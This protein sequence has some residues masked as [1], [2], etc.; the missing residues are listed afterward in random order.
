MLFWRSSSSRGGFFQFS[1]KGDAKCSSGGPP[2]LVAVSYANLLKFHAKFSDGGP[3]FDFYTKFIEKLMPNTL[4]AA[5]LLL[6]W[7]LLQFFIKTDVKRSSGCP[8]FV[9]MVCYSILNEN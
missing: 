1:L 6:W 4:L 5:L 3:L 8:P 7:F 9:V 2:P